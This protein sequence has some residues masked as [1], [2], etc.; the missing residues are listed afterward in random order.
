MLAPPIVPELLSD[1][2]HSPSCNRF[3]ELT[4]TPRVAMRHTCVV[5]SIAVV[6]LLCSSAAAEPAKTAVDKLVR[7]AVATVGASLL[8]D[9]AVIDVYGIDESADLVAV[10]ALRS[11][12]AGGKITR[13]IEPRGVTVI[14]DDAAGAAW[15]VAPYAL[16][17]VDT[18]M[19]VPEVHTKE[20]VAGLAL[21]I[22]DT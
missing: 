3:V 6:V 10:G 21:R 9:S 13:K 18:P 5:R 20:R 2:L 12:G 8:A 19:D 16:D 4:P 14:A 22:G 17:I 11:H 15:F 7:T 1:A